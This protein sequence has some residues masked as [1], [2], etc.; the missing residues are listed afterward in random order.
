MPL[1][2]LQGRQREQVVVFTVVDKSRDIEYV[3]VS[4]LS[5]SL[6]ML[7]HYVIWTNGRPFRNRQDVAAAGHM[8][9]RQSPFSGRLTL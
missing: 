9:L 4:P 6:E 2:G 5:T 3:P 8:L 7:R 1:L